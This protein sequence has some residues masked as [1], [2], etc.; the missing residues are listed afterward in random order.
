MNGEA[1]F[2]GL[3]PQTLSFAVAVEVSS[4]GA[5]SRKRAEERFVQWLG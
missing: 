4:F 1:I 5:L 3:P 2:G